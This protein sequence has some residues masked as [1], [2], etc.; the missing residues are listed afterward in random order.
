MVGGAGFGERHVAVE[1]VHRAGRGVDQVAHRGLPHCFEHA[2][3]AVHVV[4]R[5]GERIAERVADAGLR[6]EVAYDVEAFFRTQGPDCLG[7]GDVE[8]PEAQS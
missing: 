7:V 3:E 1:A 8:T 6:G 5:V 2:Q 4:R